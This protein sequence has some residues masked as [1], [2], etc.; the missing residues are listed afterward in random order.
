[1]FTKDQISILSEYSYSTR[2][3]SGA[4]YHLVVTCLVSF[5]L[6]DS[7]FISSEGLFKLIVFLINAFYSFKISYSFGV[8]N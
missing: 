8:K 4:L 6:L 2:I 3:I 7:F 1:M 5:F